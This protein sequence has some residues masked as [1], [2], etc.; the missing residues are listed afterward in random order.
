MSGPCGRRRLGVRPARCAIG[1]RRGA[2]WLARAA[3]A[4]A[5]VLLC[6]AAA[7]AAPDLPQTAMRLEVVRGPGAEGCAD[8]ALLRAEVARGLGGDPFQDDAPRMLTVRIARDGP[9]L[10]ASMALRDSEGAGETAW[11]EGFRTRNGCEALLSGVALAIVAQ[12]LTAPEGAP[13]PSEPS[14][15]SEPLLAPSPSPSRARRAAPEPAPAEAAAVPPEPL[16]LE[17]GL[18]ATLGLGI[19]PGAAAGMTLSVGV[20]RS[21]WSISVEG[22]AL[23]SMAQEVEAVPIGT[24]AFTAAALA[25]HRGRFLFGCGVTAVGVLRFVPR[26]PWTISSPRQPLL[27]VGARL[28]SAWSFSDRWSVHGYAE[29]LWNVADAVLRREREANE[30]HPALTWSSPP[31]GAVFGFGVTTIY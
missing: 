30:T 28:G 7:R 11:S 4:A 24:S 2:R 10:T 12:I 6:V 16:R 25:C 14:P 26:D 3:V 1:P 20:R 9:E 29:A 15:P 31:V 18:G 21:E 5:T 27:G 8:E 22:R 19:T 17:A 13:P 23:V